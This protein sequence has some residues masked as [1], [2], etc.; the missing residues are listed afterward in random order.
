MAWKLD[1]LTSTMG[2]CSCGAGRAAAALPA[3]LPADAAAGGAGRSGLPEASTNVVGFGGALLG[4]TPGGGTRDCNT[5][6]VTAIFR[7]KDLA[8]RMPLAVAM[9]DNLDTARI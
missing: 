9:S 2:D 4:A 6:E 5:V 1:S 7:C 8:A 3:G